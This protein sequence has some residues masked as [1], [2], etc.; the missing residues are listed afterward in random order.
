[1]HR[2]VAVLNI[3]AGILIVT[4]AA[5]RGKIPVMFL[6]HTKPAA[7]A[8]PAA[9]I[10]WGPGYRATAHRHHS[11]QLVMATKGS[12]RIRGGRRDRWLTCGAALVRPDAVH[13]VDAR[14]TPV[15]IAFVDVES[16]LG[17]ALNQ[18]IESDI[19][20]IPPNQLARWRARLGENLSERCIDRWARMEL[21]R[22]QMPL[23]IHPK[24]LRVVKYLRDRVGIADDFSL[25]TL[26]EISG[27]SQTRFMH[28]FTESVGVP[29]RPYILWLR[30]QCASCDLIHGQTVTQAAH[31]AG[32]AD[33]AHLTRTFRR[34]L[35]TSPTEL[36]LR[37][38]MSRGVSVPTTA[39]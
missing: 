22:G 19:F 23:R 20:P 31:N 21:L 15:L 17:A 18:E 6:I 4:Y 37:G 26:A 16:S 2:D 13:E 3:L 35:G 8:W 7:R 29:L 24:V 32:F 1:M 12:F 5:A 39:R 34:M 36:S 33:A 38:R 10:V 27:L 14:K 25:K 30:L 28:V 11:I 9:M